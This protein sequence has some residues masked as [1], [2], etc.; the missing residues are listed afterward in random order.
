MNQLKGTIYL[1]DNAWYKMENVIKMGIAT[2]A[3]DRSNTYITGEVER[4]MEYFGDRDNYDGNC[5]K[6]KVALDSCVNNTEGISIFITDFLN[7]NGEKSKLTDQY[8]FPGNLYWTEQARPW[9]VDIFGKWFAGEHN[10]EIIA[11]RTSPGILFL[12]LPIVEESKISW[13][14]PTQSKSSIFIIRAS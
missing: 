9:A 6:L 14:A 7:D 11:V 12:F 13:D 5:S 10:L 2:F 8:A 1:R 4:A 3:K